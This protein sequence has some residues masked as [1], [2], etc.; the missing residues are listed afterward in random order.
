MP[1]SKQ[2]KSELTDIQRN[3][4]E[5]ALVDKTDHLM[6]LFEQIDVATTDFALS[7]EQELKTRRDKGAG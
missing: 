7:R 4:F 2:S 5:Q 6:G 3:R 1:R